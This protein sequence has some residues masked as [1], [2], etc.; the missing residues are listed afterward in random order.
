[1]SPAGQSPGEPGTEPP[2]NQMVDMPPALVA[3]MRQIARDCR[4]PGRYQVII[5]VPA[6]PR[7]PRTAAISRLEL[8]RVMKLTD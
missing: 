7:G 8:I 1:M 2:E 3:L 4:G 5:E 6:A